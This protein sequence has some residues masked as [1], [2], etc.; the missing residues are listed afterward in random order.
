LQFFESVQRISL[1]AVRPQ[2]RS[3]RNNDEQRECHPKKA[4]IYITN[5]EK[6]Y[7]PLSNPKAVLK[8]KEH[9]EPGH[10]GDANQDESDLANR[11]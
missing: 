4:S 11:L 5:L 9:Y 1:A 2:M 8:R 3:N 7:I 10:V 6:I